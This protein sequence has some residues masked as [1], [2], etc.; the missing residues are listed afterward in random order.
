MLD[1]PA[2]PVG[3]TEVDASG[4]SKRAMGLRDIPHPRG[5]GL[6]GRVAV[7]TIGA[8]VVALALFYSTRL[9][10]YRE[11]WLHNKLA[12]AH[13]VADAFAPAG[14]DVTDDVAQRILDAANARSIIID[15]AR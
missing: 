10:A 8:V 11:T 13:A 3:E 6:A 1:L 9:A 14:A 5:L 7:V 15:S 2:Q 4:A 12:T